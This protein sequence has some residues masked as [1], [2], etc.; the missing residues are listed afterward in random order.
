MSANNLTTLQTAKGLRC[1]ACDMPRCWECP[2]RDLPY[3]HAKVKIR[4]AELLEEAAARKR[5]E[6]P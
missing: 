3:C 1:C 2:A 6:K 4:A 5:R